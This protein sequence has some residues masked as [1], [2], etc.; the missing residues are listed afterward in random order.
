[1]SDIIR[2]AAKDVD[3]CEAGI[4]SHDAQAAR[5][6][7]EAE[8]VAFDAEAQSYMRHWAARER[9]AADEGR[10]RLLVLKRRLEDVA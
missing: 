2:W 6:E 9:Q 5:Y 4:E 1:M 7:A 3:D 8:R 10:Q